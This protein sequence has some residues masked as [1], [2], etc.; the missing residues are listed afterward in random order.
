MAKKIKFEDLVGPKLRSATLA[1][2]DAL[3]REGIEFAIAGAAALGT[4]AA[5]R[6]SKDIDLLVD[7]SKWREA[8]RA[9]KAAGFKGV[10]DQIL[11][12][13][14]YKNGLRVDLLFGT[15]NPEEGARF[16]A[17]TETL[18]ARRLPIVRPEYLL[19]M[20]LNSPLQKHRADAINLIN[21][22]KVDTLK[23]DRLLAEDG[24]RLLRVK[25]RDVMAQ[26]EREKKTGDLTG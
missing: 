21:N 1:A 10:S 22:G 23:L 13:L 12:Q 11:A 9:L 14:D 18:F 24:D 25:L 15:G 6:M 5:P 26:A 19:W 3:K 2:T 16:T 8:I 7:P 17:R 4:Y 20:Y